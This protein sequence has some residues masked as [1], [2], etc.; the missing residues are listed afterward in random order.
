M[1]GLK[2]ILLLLLLLLP[3]R[4][5]N[6]MSINY[7]RRRLF[8]SFCSFSFS[9][10]SDCFAAA[11][12]FFSSFGRLGLAFLSFPLDWSLGFPPSPSFSPCCKNADLLIGIHTCSIYLPHTHTNSLDSG[13][14]AVHWPATITIFIVV[15]L[16]SPQSIHSSSF[17]IASNYLLYPRIRL[18]STILAPFFLPPTSHNVAFFVAFFIAIFYGAI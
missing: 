12:L 10:S 5:L 9:F 13:K 15:H 3:A 17:F 8:I 4:L 6:R 1:T 18:F 7:N 16:L 2:K 14:L 11:V